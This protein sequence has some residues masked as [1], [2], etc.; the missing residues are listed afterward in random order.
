M[1]FINGG[2]NVPE[3]LLQRHEEGHVIFFCGAGISY[4][5][6]L[7][8]FKG[9]VTDVYTALGTSPEKSEK[10][11]LDQGKYDAALELLERRYP[12]EKL[13]MREVLHDILAPKLK[14]KNAKATHKALIELSTT[15]DAKTR[16]V[17]T[18]FDRIFIKVDKKVPVFSAPMIPI[19]KNS[20]WDGIIHL[21]G[22]LPPKGESEGLR[23][24]VLTSGDF[25]LAYLTD[26]WAARF[27]SELFRNYTV[28]FVGYSIDDPVLRYMM[29][30]LAADRRLGE[31][32]P[33][34]YAFGSF[35]GGASEYEEATEAWGVK[36]VEPILYEVPP[37]KPK[38]HSALH[39]TLWAWAETYRDGIQG[40]EQI[41]LEYAMAHPLRSSQEDD[42]IG[43]LL[44]AIT[45][46][47][48]DPARL[49][50]DHNPVPKLDWL[51]VFFSPR[52]HHEHLR[53]FG[54][55]PNDKTDLAHS[56]SLLYRPS[57]Y[58]YS[59]W[60]G[61]FRSVNQNH[62]DEIMHQLA[63]WLVRHLG[64]PSLSLAL[65]RRGGQL[66]RSFCNL[67]ESRL[68]MLSELKRKGDTDEIKAIVADASEALP[69]PRMALVWRLFLTN[70]IR[71]GGMRLD[72]FGWAERV[73]I[74]GL[75]TDL[76]MEFCEILSP[77][78]ELKPSFG[79]IED[80]EDSGDSIDLE[81][82][83]E[84]DDVYSSLHALKALPDWSN[85]LKTLLP[86]LEN[87]LNDALKLKL[88]IG[89]SALAYDRSEWDL[90]S[91]EPHWQNEGFKQW[92]HLV[93]LLRDAWIETNEEAPERAAS[94]AKRWIS[95]EFPTF[96]RLAF[97]A[98]SKC[99]L[100][101]CATWSSWVL[102]EGQRALWG[103]ETK[104][105]ILRLFVVKGSGLTLKNQQLL[106]SAILDG[107]PRELFRKD[108]DES[109]VKERSDYD[110]WLRLA[111]LR[112]GADMLTHKAAKRFHQLSAAHLQWKLASDES[113]EFSIWMSGTGDPG[114][115][116]RQTIEKAP[117][118]RDELAEWLRKPGNT[119]LF[120]SDTWPEVCRNHPSNAVSAL[121]HLAREGVWPTERWQEALHSWSQGSRFARFSWC[122]VSSFIS[123]I[124]QESLCDI[125]QSMSRWLQVVAEKGRK[126]KDMFYSLCRRVMEI[127]V[128]GDGVDTDDPVMAAKNHRLGRAAQAV[129]TR[130]LA[131]KPK[132]NDGIPGTV[133]S[134]FTSLCDSNITQLVHG[135]VVLAS[136]LISLF[137]IDPEWTTEN[138]LDYF[139]W[140]N[141]R[142]EA[143]AVWSG[144]I[145]SG[146]LYK[147]LLLRLGSDFF[148]VAKHYDDLGVFGR[149][150][151]AL[152]TLTAIESPD[153]D[154][155][156]NLAEAFGSLPE[157]GLLQS[158]RVLAERLNA[159]GDQRH[160]FWENRV[161]PFWNSFWPKSNRLI[162]AKLAD[163]LASVAIASNTDFSEAVGLFLNWL[164]PLPF[165]RPAIQKLWKS[166]LCE[167]HPETCVTFL[168]R[169]IPNEKLRG[170]KLR[171]CLN[172]IVVAWPEAE[173]DARFARLRRLSL[174]T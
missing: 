167:S 28:C 149:R 36:G 79:M 162:S 78:V 17:T 141:G 3:E 82:T 35:T 102:T 30:A 170:S 18:N 94:I 81:L 42:F 15:R 8:T 23:Q 39:K 159:A 160:Q 118:Q 57:P 26:R 163:G 122:M 106:E 127:E 146:R 43:R 10:K 75:T 27:V 136:Y 44:W 1:Q 69:S 2:P 121:R 5:A 155:K 169:L 158:T 165:P 174:E 171:E 115:E 142:E 14:R 72:L 138:L 56:F 123:E 20:R 37:S 125:A 47:T 71:T 66:N 11:A 132:D 68:A 104:R 153:I 7:P 95:S 6:G 48:G 24:L 87:L 147:P 46:K 54:I 88:E 59:P 112:D 105:E 119:S 144:F 120:H 16:L 150:Y 74:F 51:D 53:Q 101:S 25:G 90:P 4:P 108:A 166:G 49:F 19:P 83:L 151:A 109:E 80:Q 139:Y 22:L 97:Y 73:K 130:W 161:K 9:L 107:P 133:K 58:K 55:I 21:H 67:I 65:V 89:D 100:I 117:L 172:L 143:L 96:K 113:D 116:E 126:N 168:E 98:A 86:D 173:Q 45:D 84:E 29:D 52:Y 33:K 12:G 111:K 60:M 114:F 34:A 50:A 62:W 156:L 164:V 91:I 140:E 64:N 128:D 93:E 110:T 31:S 32:T 135:R 92:V 154:Q 152:L 145:W 40:K 129:I 157:E 103:E 134:I 13:A 76:R 148:E 85:H 41:V 70:R 63:R 137:R 38:D 77:R 61:L 99:Q 131:E 124:P